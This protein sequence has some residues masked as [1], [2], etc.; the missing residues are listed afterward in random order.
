MEPPSP[1]DNVPWVLS[2]ATCL[3]PSSRRFK[4]IVE[5]GFLKDNFK[6]FSKFNLNANCYCIITPNLNFDKNLSIIS[7]IQY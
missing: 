4:A 3:N 7:N 2:L 1:F 5:V 6:A